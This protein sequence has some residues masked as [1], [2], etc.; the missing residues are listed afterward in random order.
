MI[1]GLR[2]SIPQRMGFLRFTL[3]CSLIVSIFLS[4]NL[5]GGYRSFPYAPA[6]DFIFI[7]PPYDFLLSAA[8]ILF[9]ICALFLVKQRLFIILSFG[10]CC[11]L[12]W[13]DLNR[14]Q[15]WFYIYNCMLIV[16]V[17]YNGRVDDPNKF[18]SVFII[19]QLIFASVY[20]YGGI[21]QLNSR[22]IESSFAEVI[23][24][25][26]KLMSN[27]Q[28]LFFKKA[29]TFMPYVFMFIGLAFT[30]SPFRYLG[31]SLAVCIHLLLLVF[32]FPSEKNGNYALWFS[33]LSFLVML[34]LLFS[35]KTKQ[36]YFSPVFLFK[37]PVFYLMVL[38][39]II[40]P[41]LNI[42]NR[43]P[44]FLSANYKSGNNN[45]ALIILN[46]STK[47]KLPYYLQGFCQPYKHAYVF[48]FDSWTKHEIHTTCFPE[49][50]VFTSIYKGLIKVSGA[51]VKD[52]QLVLKPKDKLLC[53]P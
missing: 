26:A 52:I 15:P 47:D 45:D 36:R 9:W 37:M 31:I 44:D 14:L 35:G 38:L 40:L 49:P 22:F 8:A 19:L 48:N 34:I 2:L 3:I 28:F 30:I 29:G 6:S 23:A 17:F 10:L 43:W 53:K 51:D 12:V 27:R 1:D 39:L 5:W 4:F 21:S 25:M 13:H 50:R 7:V 41:S 32:L 20:F 16:F 18:T 11:V 24:P 33:N 42:V 46:Q